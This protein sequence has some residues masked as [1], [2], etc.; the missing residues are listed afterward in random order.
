MEQLESIVARVVSVSQ[1]VAFYLF[2]YF[3]DD[4]NIGDQSGKNQG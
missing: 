3:F 4:V 2:I 1:L